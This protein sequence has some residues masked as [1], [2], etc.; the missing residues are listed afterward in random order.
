M[1]WGDRMYYLV[2]TSGYPNYG[3]ELIA[4]MWLR[5]LAEVAPDQEVW[6]DC[7]S[8]GQAAVLLDGIHPRAR[9][10]DTFWRLCWEAPADEPWEV[11]RWVGH[12][13]HNPGMACRWVAGIDLAARA[14]VV[15]LI[16]GGY[17]NRIWP[18]H[19]GLL[20]AAVSA[21]QRS[22]GRAVMTGQ[23]LSPVADH[24]ASLLRG[25]V[26]HFEFADVRDEPSLALIG[27]ATAVGCTGDDMFFGIGPELYWRSEEPL[28]EVMLCLQSDLLDMPR[29]ELASFVTETLRAWDVTGDRIGVVEGIPGVDRAIFDLIE[30]D[31]PGIRFYPFSEIWREGLPAGPGQTWIS[32]R[33]HV[34]LIAAAAGAA[35]AAVSINADYYDNK[36]RSLTDRGSGWLLVDDLTLPPRPAGGAFSPEALR[37][38]WEAK[39]ALAAK[40]YT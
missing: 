36:H 1:Y 11:T 29:P 23:G 13:V 38:T 37:S 14:D 34:H 6:L 4:A 27:D 12:A 25:L 28:R 9:F 19:Y 24:T 8:P 17:I 40:I 16:G 31:F 22:G 35:G 18:R 7:P 5:H 32:T 3:D 26:S 20:A 21:V 33:F 2:G 10:T 15:H 39:S 30:R